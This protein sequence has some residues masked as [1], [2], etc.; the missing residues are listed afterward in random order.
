MKQYKELL[1]KIKENGTYKPAAREGMPGTQS[2]FGY[3][4]RHNLADGFPLLTTKKMFW[5]GV[6]IEL[7]WFLRGDTNIKYLVDNGVNIWNEDAYNYYQKRCKEFSAENPS[8]N[9]LPVNFESFIDFVKTGQ[10][11]GMIIPGYNFGD[12]GFQYGKVWRRW[13]APKEGIDGRYI[14]GKIDQ[15]GNLV[16]GLKKN[17]MGRRHIVTAWD[18]A[19]DTDL[20]LTWCH[21][22]FQF[23]CRPLTTQQRFEIWKE[24]VGSLYAGRYREVHD[25]IIPQLDHAQVPKYYLDCQ[26]YQRSA[27]VVLGVPFNLAS[28]ALLTHIMAKMTNM[29]PGEFIHTFGDVHIYDNHREAVK[30]QLARE[31]KGLPKLNIHNGFVV[32]WDNIWNK[33]LNAILEDIVKYGWENIIELQEYNPHPKL[34]SETK[35]STG[36]TK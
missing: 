20:A 14:K 19:H 5:K 23:N 2:L 10:Y 15:I 34:E 3:Q 6:V 24:T 36:L 35:L 7:L 4:Y 32:E 16:E 31:P 1:K 17:P 28:Y 12:C 8:I 33:D 11:N 22:L 27:D 13:R 26:L 29:I 30:E 9:L 18:P 21:A 25:N